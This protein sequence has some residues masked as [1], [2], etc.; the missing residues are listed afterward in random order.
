VALGRLEVQRAGPILVNQGATL[1]STLRCKLVPSLSHVGAVLLTGISP[2]DDKG[3]SLALMF[4]SLNGERLTHMVNE[5][6]HV[7]VQRSPDQTD[8]SLE[9]ESAEGTKTLVR[10]PSY[11]AGG[12]SDELKGVLKSDAHR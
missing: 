5:P 10:F 7:W 2:A 4:D 6:T 8:Q 11:Q 12:R 1:K 3:E 9:I